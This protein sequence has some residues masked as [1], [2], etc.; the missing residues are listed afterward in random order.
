VEPYW[1]LL[2]QWAPFPEDYKKPICQL[3]KNEAK[4]QLELLKKVDWD[5]V[6]KSFNMVCDVLPMD[7]DDV[8]YIAIYPSNTEMP[9]TILV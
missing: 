9:G 8:M 2:S 6:K 3:E 1:N 4:Q 5:R 7:D